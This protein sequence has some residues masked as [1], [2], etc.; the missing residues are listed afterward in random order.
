[1]EFVAGCRITRL[2]ARTA[3]TVPER[4]AAASAVT[5]RTGDAVAAGDGG[6]VGP[7]GRQAVA[8]EDVALV[9]FETDQGSVGSLVVSQ[10]SAGRKNRLWF[11]LDGE[12]GSVVFDQEQ[13]ESLWLGRREGGV[14][15]PRDPTQ[16]APDAAR[17]ASL[18]AGH[19]Q[20]YHDCF[21]L[22]VADAYQAMAGVG[23]GEAAGQVPDGLPLVADGVRAVQLTEAV[24]ASA[25]SHAWSDVPADA[26]A[27]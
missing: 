22:F 9:L 21:D 6:G 15:L 19:A 7:G 23:N 5:F 8:T 12:T 27:T 13:P 10:V 1:V 16:M 18:P 14:T 17:L 3:T 20:G 25:R 4:V 2:L 11:E 26:T 24:L